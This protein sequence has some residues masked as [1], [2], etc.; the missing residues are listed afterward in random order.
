[1][2]FRT[3]VHLSTAPLLCKDGTSVERT[4]ALGLGQDCHRVIFSKIMLWNGT[5]HGLLAVGTLR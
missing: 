4:V 1:M 2:K 3:C 5:P